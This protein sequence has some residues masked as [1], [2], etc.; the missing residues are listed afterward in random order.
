MV[1]VLVINSIAIILLIIGT[2]MITKQIIKDRITR[3]LEN[4][5]LYRVKSK[6]YH[7]DFYVIAD[8]ENEAMNFVGMMLFHYKDLEYEEGD[9]E[10]ERLDNVFTSIE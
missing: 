10:V 9:I 5:R 6:K 8:H 4:K 3:R 1:I 2:Y 7:S